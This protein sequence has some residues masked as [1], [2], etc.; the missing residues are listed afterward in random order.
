M[1]TCM[2]SSKANRMLVFVRRAAVDINDV[3]VR[4]AL[5][6]SLARGWFAYASQVWSPQTANNI[7]HMVKV[8]RRAT[9][10]IVSLPYKTDISHKKRLQSTYILPVCYW[11]EYL[12]MVYI[13][14][15]LVYNSDQ[16]ISIKYR[17]RVTRINDLTN[18]ILLEIPRSRTVTYQNSFFVRAPSVWN[19]LP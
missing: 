5:Y 13:Y 17:S 18:V 9:K 16:N 8:Q 14:K 3:Q 7:V 10:F 12:D 4:K 19:T 15:C 11:Q 1:L 2:T 6:L